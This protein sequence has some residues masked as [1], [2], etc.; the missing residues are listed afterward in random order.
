MFQEAIR[1]SSHV[2]AKDPAQFASQV[3]GRLLP[4]RDQTVVREFAASHAE[5]APRPW[6]RL[7]H[8]T[9]HPPGTPL[10][11]T[12]EGHSDLVDGVAVSPNGRRAVCA[13][14]D[15]TLKVWDLETGRELRTLQGHSSWVDGVAVSPFS[16][17]RRL[18]EMDGVRAGCDSNQNGFAD[19]NRSQ[20]GQLPRNRLRPCFNQFS[21]DVIDALWGTPV[22][23]LG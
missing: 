23:L 13:S 12:L 11:R 1:L 19:R 18:H 9:L 10:I 8:P 14:R 22:T 21:G 16:T 15:K 2:I 17:S 5:G 4:H 20:I 3:V 7:L 6:L